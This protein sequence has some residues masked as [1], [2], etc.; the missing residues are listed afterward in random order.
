MEVRSIERELGLPDSICNPMLREEVSEI[1]RGLPLNYD[2]GN[3]IRDLDQMKGSLK[4]SMINLKTCLM[5]ARVYRDAT[6]H[7]PMPAN[8]Q[9]RIALW[10]IS[11][12]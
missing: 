10:R 6:I 9:E 1:L 8:N 12:F 5:R 2:T 7:Y 4:G 3:D 11:T